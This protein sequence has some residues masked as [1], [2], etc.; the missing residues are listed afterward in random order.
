MRL[1][2]DG[3]HVRTQTIPNSVTPKNRLLL[4]ET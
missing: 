3:Y 2:Q 4:T 1:E